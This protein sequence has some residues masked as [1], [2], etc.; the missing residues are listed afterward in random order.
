MLPDSAES[1]YFVAFPEDD[2]TP[3]EDFQVNTLKI[4]TNKDDFSAAQ[5]FPAVYFNIPGEEP[6]WL[7]TVNASSFQAG[8]IY[9]MR[10]YV[11]DG[12]HIEDAEFPQNSS[13][14]PYKTYWSF[15]VTP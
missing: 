7:V 14:D 11:N 5:S 4:S 8:Q 15:V 10:Y 1:F 6:V 3:L 12:Q 2:I 9:Y 13:I